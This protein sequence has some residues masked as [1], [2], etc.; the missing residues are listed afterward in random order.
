[1]E[2]LG[3]EFDYVNFAEGIKDV[4]HSLDYIRREF[5]T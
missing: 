2:K 5:K 4:T 3:G 1:M